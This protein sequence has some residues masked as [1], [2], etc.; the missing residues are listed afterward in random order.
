M[1]NRKQQKMHTCAWCSAGDQHC[2]LSLHRCVDHVFAVTY[3]LNQRMCERSSHIP[4]LFCKFRL[5]YFSDFFSLW[6]FLSVV[7]VVRDATET[8]VTSSSSS[9]FVF[10]FLSFANASRLLWN[11]RCYSLF[12]F[13]VFIFS[14]ALLLIVSSQLGHIRQTKNKTNERIMFFEESY[15]NL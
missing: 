6:I 14:C 15:K 9:S 4:Q 8:R 3:S 13:L 11:T 7:F 12:N 1:N 5:F 10:I 2:P